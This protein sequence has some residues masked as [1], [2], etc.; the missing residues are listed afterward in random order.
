MK[1]KFD[2]KIDQLAEEL[3][4]IELDVLTNYTLAD[5]IREGC[6]ATVKAEGWGNGDSACSLTAAGIFLEA[7]KK[8]AQDRGYIPKSE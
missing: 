5:A 3:G 6:K 7:V 8:A 4:Q 1:E 2:E